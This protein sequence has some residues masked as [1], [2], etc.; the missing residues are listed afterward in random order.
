[1]LERAR[2]FWQGTVLSTRPER[3]RNDDPRES[4]LHVEHQEHS[5]AGVMGVSVA[6][7]RSLERMGPKRT[8]TSLL[9]L[10]QVDGFDCMSCA[11]PDPAPA[12]S[13]CAATPTSRATGRWASGS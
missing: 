2:D 3:R 12:S 9:R 7:K 1:M 13:P 4:R 8:A 6:L 5:A 11:W 10:N